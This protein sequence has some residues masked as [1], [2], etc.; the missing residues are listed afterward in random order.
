MKIKIIGRQYS[1]EARYSDWDS[2]R[3][4][5]RFDEVAK[6]EWE[7]EASNLKEAEEWLAK[8]HPDMYMGANI[9][10]EN[11]DFSCLAVPCIEYG[12]GN[13]ETQSARIAWVKGRYR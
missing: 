8:N 7:I 1:E 6:Q 5:P 11:N 4:F 9:I 12:I 13:Y 10:C 3:E 2:K